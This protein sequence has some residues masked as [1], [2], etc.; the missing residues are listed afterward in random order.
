MSGVITVGGVS[1]GK[2]LASFPSGYT[3]N[4]GSGVD[5]FAP[6]LN[7]RAGSF[8]LNGSVT[9]GT[10]TAIYIHALGTSFAAPFV[11]G[12]VAD[13]LAAHPKAKVNDISDWIKS[14]AS[15]GLQGNLHGSPNKFLYLAPGGF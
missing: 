10:Y 4:Y 14:K 2:S 13:Y 1:E 3:S 7:L 5:V 15:G 12:G 9:T 8:Q 11:T 6:A